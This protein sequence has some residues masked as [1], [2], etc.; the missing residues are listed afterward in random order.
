MRRLLV[1]AVIILSAGVLYQ[2]RY[3]FEAAFNAPA[4][5]R[6]LGMPGSHAFAPGASYRDCHTPGENCEAVVVSV[7]NGARR[8]LRMQAYSF[9]SR[10]IGEA[11][12]SARRRGVDVSLLVDKSDERD[13]YGVTAILA[14]AG[15]SVRTDYLPAIAHNK[16]IVADWDEKPVLVTGSFNF[17]RS[18]QDRNAENVLV[19]AGDKSL[20]DDYA[21]AF[22]HRWQ[23]SRDFQVG[24]ADETRRYRDGRRRRNRSLDDGAREAE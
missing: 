7:I 1:P 6:E 20:A 3:V 22:D 12:L 4:V 19:I 9:T 15:V 17:T 14:R 18:A 5:G 16:V 11:L 8:N 13:T 2:N 23:V 10:P 24:S 21:Q